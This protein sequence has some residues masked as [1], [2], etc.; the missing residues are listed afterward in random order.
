MKGLYESG[1]Q[2]AASLDLYAHA[3]LVMENHSI[4]SATLPGKTKVCLIDDQSTV[5]FVFY[6]GAS[7]TDYSYFIF[8]TY[9]L[10]YQ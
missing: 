5:N 3:K 6:I 8:K 2:K 4:Y 9:S 10:Y 1:F 7:P